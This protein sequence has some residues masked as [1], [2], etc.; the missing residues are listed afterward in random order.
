MT[1]DDRAEPGMEVDVLAAVGIPDPAAPGAREDARRVEE[2]QARRHA[3]GDDPLCTL[4]QLDRARGRRMSSPG[5]G[6]HQAVHCRQSTSGGSHP[7]RVADRASPIDTPRRGLVAWTTV[8][9]AARLAAIDQDS[10]LR[11]RRDNDDGRRTDRDGLPF[12]RRRGCRIGLRTHL[13]HRSTRRPGARS[14]RSRSA[15]PR[16]SIGRSPPG[17]RP[18]SRAPGRR[19]RRATGRRSCAGWPT[20]STQD[21]DRIGAIESRDTGKPLGQATAR[22][23]PGRRLPHL[24]RRPRRA[25]QRHD[26]PGR[27]GLLRLL[28]PR[29]VRRRRR[30]QPVELP[31]PARLLED[32]A[33]AG[34]RQLASCS[35]WPSRRRCRPRSWAA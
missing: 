2:A 4:R 22:G 14:P 25:A 17:E 26:L 34:G 24:L 10:G 9:D 18:S 33:G 6:C 21:A 35:R 5:I 16:T 7:S 30:D 3:A 12:H 29:A 11:P 13:R 28:R 31:V 32:R 27:R 23:P 19:P 20:S 1:E 15:R 8:D